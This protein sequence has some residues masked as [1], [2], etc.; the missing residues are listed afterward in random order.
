MTFSLEEKFEA[1]LRNKVENENPRRPGLHVS[2]I[3]GD[4]LRKPWYR[5]VD[6][7]TIN[8]SP[9]DFQS[10]TNFYYGTICHESFEGMFNR[11]EVNL[12]INPFKEIHERQVKD[13]DKEMAE[14]PFEWVSGSFDAIADDSDDMD[15]KDINTIVDYKT[16]MKAVS[17]PSTQYVKQINFYSYMYYVTTG[18]QVEKGALIYLYKHKGFREYRIFRFPLL[19]PEENREH[20]M[21]AMKEIGG[22]MAPS[23]TPHIFCTTCQYREVCDPHGFYDYKLKKYIP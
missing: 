4:C 21:T 10:I 1:H 19:T 15:E 6:D 5:M 13:I 20:M 22:E 8:K 7:G 2:D 11:M 14:H 9:Y 3:V 17:E 23:R 16:T 18:I 12:C